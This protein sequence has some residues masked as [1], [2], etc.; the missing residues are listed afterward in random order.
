MRRILLLTT[1]AL[2]LAAAMALSAA[3]MAKPASATVLSRC[4]ERV[5]AKLGPSFDPSGYT[6]VGGTKGDDDFTGKATAGQDVFC[7]FGGTDSIR[8]LDQ[9]DIFLGGVDDD[10]VNEDTY[11][12]F[13]GG[14]GSEYVSYNRGTFY[15]SAGNDY[16]GYNY[17][18]FYGG[19]DS[20]QVT[21]NEG[22]FYGQM[23]DDS[24]YNNFGTFYGGD[25][26]DVV[27]SH[28]SGTFEQ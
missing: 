20:D 7:G 5:Q 24:V 19:A 8:T 3:A 1:L 14:A 22:T 2:M 12:T 10:L 27:T 4:V 21:A 23:G 25:G 13:Y 11:G 28:D 16:A 15:G 17:S 18:T 6:F 26:A 9:G